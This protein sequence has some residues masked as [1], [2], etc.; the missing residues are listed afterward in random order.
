MSYTLNNPSV[1]TTYIEFNI[2]FSKLIKQ[3]TSLY[4]LFLKF[5]LLHSSQLDK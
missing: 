4:Q 5:S 3:D 1:K 2:P